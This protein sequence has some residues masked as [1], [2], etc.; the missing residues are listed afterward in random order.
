MAG[1]FASFFFFCVELGNDRQYHT[2]IC[3]QKSH[4]TYMLIMKL[5]LMKI[6]QRGKPP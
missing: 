4:Q 1:H 5:V 3:M 2:H 6:I